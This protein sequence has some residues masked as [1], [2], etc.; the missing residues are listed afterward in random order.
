MNAFDRVYWF[1]YNV[2]VS[3]ERLFNDTFRLVAVL[4]RAGAYFKNIMAADWFESVL[5]TI[6]DCAALGTSTKVLDDIGMH[7]EAD[8]IRGTA[9]D[10]CIRKRMGSGLQPSV[11]PAAFSSLAKVSTIEDNEGS[12]HFPPANQAICV[13]RP[14]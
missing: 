9:F 12:I 2:E 7:E 10:A 13:S 11:A 1:I 5:R 4:G 8:L 14:F 3:A 6:R